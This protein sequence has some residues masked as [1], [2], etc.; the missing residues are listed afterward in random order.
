VLAGTGGNGGGGLV[1]GRRLR[2][3]GAEVAVYLTALPD[4]LSETTRLQLSVLHRMDVP[5][6]VAV[7]GTRLPRADLVIDALIG[8][9]LRGAPV[10]LTADLIRAANARDAPVLAL[11]IPAESTPLQERSTTRPSALRQPS[12]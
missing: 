2:T 4:R 12:R 7:L 1:G 6:Q 11:D 3:W 9:S 5:V 8:Y 10:G